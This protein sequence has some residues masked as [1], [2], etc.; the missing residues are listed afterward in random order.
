VGTAT[1]AF[2]L[3]FDTAAV[4]AALATPEGAAA[5][6]PGG[7]GLEEA[8]VLEHELPSAVATTT[9]AGETLIYTDTG[10]AGLFE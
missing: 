8:L 3:R 7:D 9:W 6:A 5:L 2:V 4:A 1:E 10:A